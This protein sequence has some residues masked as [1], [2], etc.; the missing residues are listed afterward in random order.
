MHKESKVYVF[1]S[2][3]APKNLESLGADMA[4]SL[5]EGYFVEGSESSDSLVI[6]VVSKATGAPGATKSPLAL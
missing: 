6:F 4:K 5:S 2:G 3:D 1:R